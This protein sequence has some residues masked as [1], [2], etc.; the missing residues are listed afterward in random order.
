M[1]PEIKRL[2]QPDGTVAGCD[3]RVQF[4]VTC[5]RCHNRG[6][7]ATSCPILTSENGT[8]SD[9]CFAQSSSTLS[10]TLL[11]ID[12]GST[13]NS[14]SSRRLLE[15]ITKYDGIRPYSNSGH[16]DYHEAGTIHLFP[17]LRAC[18][19]SRF[20]ANII[21]FC[22]LS[23]YYIVIVDTLVNPGI[24]CLPLSSLLPR[25]PSVFMALTHLLI[26]LKKLMIVKCYLPRI[27]YLITH[28]SSLLR[29]HILK[30]FSLRYQIVRLHISIVYPSVHNPKHFW[31]QTCLN[32]Y[33]QIRV[34]F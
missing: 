4:S 21:S 8:F 20:L 25:Y 28:H 32:T 23:K 2:V 12:I 10:P 33:I 3:G 22:E 30:I 26:N 29:Y 16:L 15:N 11:I 27:Y 7:Y 1:T 9:F 5:F 13:V 31:P 17:A 19:S 14:L 6:H 34:C 18:T 24:T